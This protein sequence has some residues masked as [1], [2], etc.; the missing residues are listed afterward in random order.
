MEPTPRAD[1]DAL[2][3]QS[4]SYAD[5]V[6]RRKEPFLPSAMEMD[7]RGVQYDLDARFRQPGESFVF[8]AAAEPSSDAS[9]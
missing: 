1:M 2:L 6:L 5:H 8:G 7:P 4:L 9:R 3:Q